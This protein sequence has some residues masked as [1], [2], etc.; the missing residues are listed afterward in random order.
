MSS[1]IDKLQGDLQSQYVAFRVMMFV[2]LIVGCL[3]AAAGSFGWAFG[4]VIIGLILGNISNAKLSLI[5]Q[6][7][8]LDNQ[9]RIEGKLDKLLEGE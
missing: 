6:N 1:I 5:N 2:D 4:L 8:V 3:C 7:T 9:N